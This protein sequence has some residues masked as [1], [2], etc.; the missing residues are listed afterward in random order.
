[1]SDLDSTT[2]SI[3][4]LQAGHGRD[5]LAEADLVIAVDASSQEKEVVHGR[6]K[7]ERAIVAGCEDALVVLRVE[8]DMELDD[9][10]WLIEAIQSGEDDEDDEPKEDDDLDD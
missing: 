6:D 3:D 8:L 9:Q 5:L 4:E 7:L 1:M 10:D 2:I